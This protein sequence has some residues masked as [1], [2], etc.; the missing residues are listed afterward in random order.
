MIEYK[1]ANRNYVAT[2]VMKTDCGEIAI[3]N[4]YNHD[5]KVDIDLLIQHCRSPGRVR[6]IIVGDM[7]KV[8]SYP[9]LPKILTPFRS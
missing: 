7:S 1:D 8:L 5:K 2:L 9:L 3:H 6:D 4:V